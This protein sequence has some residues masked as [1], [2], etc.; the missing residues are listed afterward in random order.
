MKLAILGA[1]GAVGMQMIKCIEERKINCDLKLLASKNSAGKKVKVTGKTAE[2]LNARIILPMHY[3]TEYNRE[4]P[5]SGPETF[6][7]LFDPGAICSGAEALRIAKKDME[8][9]PRIVLF[10]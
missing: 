6:T 1:T 4:W 7:T 5:I 10:K 8:C 9:Q 3:K 2:Q